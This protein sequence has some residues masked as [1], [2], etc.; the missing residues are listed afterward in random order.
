MT[1]G[2][3][4]TVSM[5]PAAFLST[6]KGA[7]TK[8]ELYLWESIGKF[9]CM[10]GLTKIFQRSIKQ[11][12]ARGFSKN[13]FAS[14]C[15]STFLFLSSQTSSL[16]NTFIRSQIQVLM[17]LLPPSITN[18]CSVNVVCNIPSQGCG[19]VGIKNFRQ[20][21]LLANRGQRLDSFVVRG[22]DR[23]VVFAC[24]GTTLDFCISLTA[25]WR[26][27]DLCHCLR[28]RK[29]ETPLEKLVRRVFAPY[30][31]SKW[32]SNLLSRWSLEHERPSAYR[33]AF[34]VARLQETL[35]R[36]SLNLSWAWHSSGFSFGARITWPGRWW[37]RLFFSCGWC[38]WQGWHCS[39][40]RFPTYASNS[41]VQTS[42]SRW[43]SCDKPSRCQKGCWWVVI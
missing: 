36:S 38:C 13:T 2:P 33:R 32:V 9:V 28:F 30:H 41:E 10:L 31:I 4:C 17:S 39:I 37:C 5:S 6:W 3:Y 35:E 12:H 29:S 7:V 15:V 16:E 23:L 27:T 8:W 24:H 26:H 20:Q 18:L 14:R 42:A 25:S 19:W 43:C 34:R 40:C 11:K 21:F 22:L 1:R